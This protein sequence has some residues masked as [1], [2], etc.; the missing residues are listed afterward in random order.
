MLSKSL[1]VQLSHKFS[2]LRVKLWRK[3][4]K[5]NGVCKLSNF[6]LEER[7]TIDDV[8]Q[9]F[10]HLSVGQYW[11]GFGQH[12]AAGVTVNVKLKISFDTII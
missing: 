10:E 3:A 8:D 12:I 2:L 5:S 6:W 9:L 7:Q 1:K 4:W 11:D